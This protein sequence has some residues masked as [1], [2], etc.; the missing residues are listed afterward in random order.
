MDLIIKYFITE[1]HVTEVVAKVLAKPLL[2]YDDINKEFIYWLENRNYDCPN[3]TNI[4]GYTAASVA[5]IA[6]HLDV[7]GVYGFLVTLRDNPIKAQ[8]Y[9]DNGFPRK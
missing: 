8:E 2:K 4:N 9:F 3:P 7:A 1:K 5:K 6:P